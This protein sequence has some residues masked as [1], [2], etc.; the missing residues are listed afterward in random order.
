MADIS[1]DLAAI[2]KLTGHAEY[3]A[4][5]AAEL[6]DKKALLVERYA[7]RAP[8]K[9]LLMISDV[10]TMGLSNSHAVVEAFHTCGAVN[11]LADVSAKAPL[12]GREALLLMQ[13]QLIITSY[14]VSDR[15]S[16]L[17]Q[18]GFV[19]P[20]KPQHASVDPDMMLRQTPRLL[21][22]IEQFCEHV[23]TARRTQP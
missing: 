18:R 11:V 6:L 17:I 1:H 22:A 21:T 8:V 19:A 3:A 20:P 5:R 14:P 10:P 15:N 4:E 16:W 13:P 12:I 2:G 9:T 7:E 23:D